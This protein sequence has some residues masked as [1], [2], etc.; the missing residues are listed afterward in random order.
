MPTTLINFV[1]A[2]GFPAG[3]YNTLFQLLPKS[4]Q[5]ISLEK[6][7]HNEQYPVEKNWQPLV[8]ELIEFVQEQLESHHENKV[9]A[10]GHSFGGVISFI[11]ACQ[12]PELFEGLIMLDPPVFTGTSALALKMIKK[13]RFIDKFSPA[14]KAQT[15]RT[16]W[17]LNTDIAKLLSRRPLFKN[18][19]KRCLDDYVNYGTVEK[20]GQLEL[21][22]STQV[23]ADI[24]RHL[25]ENLS[26]YKNMLTV[27]ATLIYAEAT[28][29]CPHSFFTK[30]AKLNKK[31]QITT[32][33]GGHL[34]P[35]EYPENTVNIIT[36][37][38]NKLKKINNK[39]EAI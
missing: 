18:F 39:P 32:S 38:I 14:G 29:V 9:F 37:T 1:H 35:F 30:F 17:P 28:D 16:I 27:P 19:D 11:A 6:Y 36:E 26:K 25:P 4:Y 34:F 12:R 13:T 31:I 5:V 8:D 7:G 10:I 24:F 21:V 23:E 33:P 15:R 3:S 20:N 22:F 2:N